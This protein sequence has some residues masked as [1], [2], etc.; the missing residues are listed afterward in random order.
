MKA[1]AGNSIS[2]IVAK[3]NRRDTLRRVGANTEHLGTLARTNCEDKAVF[4]IVVS[5]RALD[6]Q[7]LHVEAA[8]VAAEMRE[9]LD[10]RLRQ[11]ATGRVPRK[12][13]EVESALAALEAERRLRGALRH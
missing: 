3:R 13:M 7:V 10:T 11:R 1:Q 5:L 8:R 6:D 4:A 12:V 9:V 2:Q